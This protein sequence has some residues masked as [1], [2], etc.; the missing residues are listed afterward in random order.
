MDI[1]RPFK[2]EQDQCL[3]WQIGPLKL[4]LQRT[5]NEWHLASERAPEEEDA[6]G[7][8]T[9]CNKPEQMQWKRWT[10]SGE[11]NLVQNI[12]VMPDRSIIVRPET[13]LTIPHG[14][15]ALFYVTIPV[16]VR[17][18]VGQNAQMTLC[19]EPTVILS[20]SWFGQPTAGELCYSLRTSARRTLDRLGRRPHGAVCPVR[21][22]NDAAVQLDF[23]RLCVQVNHLNIYAGKGHMWTNE[24][25]VTYKG[26]EKPTEIDFAQ[27][28]PTGDDVGELI[29]E[30]REPLSRGFMQKGFDTFKS[31]TGM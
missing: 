2:I 1:W 10:A 23:E 9:P 8:A 20:H 18:A 12:P 29:T 22:Q 19:E 25:K 4:W 17:V 30:A 24:V 15:Q 31:F 6:L 27:R 7:P 28:S 21:V 3:S 26:E 5:E 14:N 11:S 16:W 13:P